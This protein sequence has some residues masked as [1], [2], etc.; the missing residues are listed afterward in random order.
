MITRNRK[1]DKAYKRG[2]PKPRKNK[3]IFL[4]KRYKNVTRNLYQTRKN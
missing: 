3:K 4:D 1:M 2:P